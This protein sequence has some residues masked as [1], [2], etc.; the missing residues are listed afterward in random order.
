MQTVNQS[1]K[2]LGISSKYTCRGF[3]LIELMIVVVIVVILSAIAIPSYSNYVIRAKVTEATSEL[4][5]KRVQMEQ[6]YQDNRQYAQTA[7]AC[8]DSQSANF[9]FTCVADANTYT[10]TATGKNAI[11]GFTYTIDQA[12]VKTSNITSPADWAS[13]SSNCWVT[14]QGGAC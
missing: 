1:K 11:S 13:T 7:T 6:Y 12:N 10:I 3:S 5:T 4:A 9:S 2:C 14:K 8:A